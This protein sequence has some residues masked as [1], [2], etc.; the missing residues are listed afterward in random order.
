MQLET[1][2]CLDFLAYKRKAKL[3]RP[4]RLFNEDYVTGTDHQSSSSAVM[5]SLA[6]NDFLKNLFN[7]SALFFFQEYP[8]ELGES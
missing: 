4:Q 1:S 2:L 6:L 3:C 7:K 5:I 8:F